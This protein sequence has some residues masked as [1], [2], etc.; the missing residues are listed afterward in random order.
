MAACAA[1]G[2]DDEPKRE[3]G[4][5]YDGG[6]SDEHWM[7]GPAGRG[8]TGGSFTSGA[9]KGG[10]GGRSGASA[11]A[12][13]SGANQGVP[14]SK[15]GGEAIADQD[16]GNE[17]TALPAAANPFVLA[18][19]DPFSTFGADVDTASY[20]GFAR[21][22]ALGYL[23]AAELV[24]LE[25]FVNYFDYDY[26]TPAL[27][28][29]HPFAISL[30]AAPSAGAR[31]TTILRVGI[32]AANPPP[33]AKK[34]AHVVFL[35][36]TSGSMAE[37]LPLV[38]RV[39]RGALDQLDAEDRVSL[40]TYA[41]STE[42]RLTP[43]LVSAEDHILSAIEGLTSAGSTNGASGIDLAYQQAASAFI[44]S[45]IN[46]VVLCTDGDFNV[47]ASSDEALVELI[48]SKR[49]TG[50]TLTA[51]GFGTNRV[52]DSMMEKVSNAGNGSFSVVTSELQADRYVE[53][54]LLATIVHVA[55]DVKLQIE[56]NPERVRAYRLLGYENRAIADD[57]FRDDAIDAGEVGAG[58]RVTVLY[59][60]VLAGAPLP[61]GVVPVASQ[62]D[63][64]GSG[65]EVDAADLALVKVRYKT[66]AATDR[67]PASELTAAFAPDAIASDPGA[68]NA[69]LRWAEAVAAFAESLKDS[70]FA[71]QDRL[72]ALGATIE[73]QR[74]RDRDRAAFADQFKKARALLH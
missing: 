59:E 16:G 73:A 22:I 56:F 14:G 6:A 20:D 38:Q 68:A 37:E 24:R 17:D 39:L 61:D 5:N 58:H 35:V 45:G 74:G 4:G 21:D 30:A 7:P 41:G 54:R 70:S 2:C 67:D 47:G 52:N 44:E 25:D 34:R 32:Q 1:A 46:H 40:V 60:L 31:P 50:V 57:D 48:K 8:G 29:P 23:P 66:P 64:Q 26:A 51:L 9:G 18:A 62:G 12:G 13:A 10:S 3:P 69:D 27:D 63:A 28:A 43:T 49:Q 36:D 65:R 42:V 53:E 72:D 71:E 11:A 33:E 19:Y 15:D 55:K